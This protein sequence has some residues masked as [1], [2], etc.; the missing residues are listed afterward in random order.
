MS[1]KIDNSFAKNNVYK[2]GASEETAQINI[3]PTKPAKAPKPE[4]IFSNQSLYLPFGVSNFN[5]GGFPKFHDPYGPKLNDQYYKM[6]GEHA[7]PIGFIKNYNIFTDNIRDY[8]TKVLPI[9]Y[10]DSIPMRGANH[11]YKTLYERKFLYEYVK[12]NLVS[13]DEGEEGCMNSNN[14]INLLRQL[15]RLSYNPVNYNILY[16]NPLQGLEPGVRLYRSCYPIT[17]DRKKITI[18]S[19]GSIGLH[20]KFYNKDYYDEQ[21]KNK[22]L[23]NTFYEVEKQFYLKIRDEI[24]LKN[25]C[26]NFIL[27]YTYY[28]CNNCNEPFKELDKKKIKQP[29]QND[30][31]LNMNPYKILKKKV[32]SKQKLKKCMIILTESPNLNILQWME[33]TRTYGV[34]KRSQSQYGHHTDTEWKS[35]YIQLFA[36]IYTLQQKEICIKNF[37]YDNIMIKILNDKNGYWIYNIGGIEYY[38]PNCGFIVVIDCGFK[39]SIDNNPDNH[40]SFEADDFESMWNHVITDNPFGQGIYNANI[41]RPTVAIIDF[42]K[43]IHKDNKS[44]LKKID[45]YSIFY[46]NFYS[47]MHSKCG[48]FVENNEIS[49][50]DIDVNQYSNFYD[51]NVG[52]LVV[53][54]NERSEYIWA[55]FIGK[56]VTD[57]EE[58]WYI[59]LNEEII[60]I[61]ESDIRKTKLLKVE[62]ILKENYDYTVN[63]NEPPLAIYTI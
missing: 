30:F 39:S 23:L 1:S 26:P 6:G 52:E 28:N 45:N 47:F 13:Y 36:A 55:I 46:K 21:K 24:I 16:T 38:V 27:M 2:T 14:G 31:T 29:M 33:N 61:S 54:I 34:N 18:C 3:Y 41:A 48:H 5:P 10:E 50:C 63:L 12:S 19:K 11:T 43:N 51:Y 44:N 58:D 22:N 32:N 35:F 37:D 9:L 49:G 57:E 25:I 20:I 40:I 7:M 17:T 15:K 8:Q 60:K 59:C 53:Y 4:D 62:Q 56:I 42:I